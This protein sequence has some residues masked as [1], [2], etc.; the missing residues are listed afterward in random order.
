MIKGNFLKNV[1]SAASFF[2]NFSD[3]RAKLELSKKLTA[4]RFFK[5]SISQFVSILAIVSHPHFL[6]DSNHLSSTTLQNKTI[7]VQ[8]SMIDIVFEISKI[9]LKMVAVSL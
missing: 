6:M 2:Q 9:M 5:T 8:L 4:W 1:H 7:I 3:F